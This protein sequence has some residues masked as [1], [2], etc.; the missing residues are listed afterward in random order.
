LYI[1]LTN[2]TFLGETECFYTGYPDTRLGGSALAPVCEHEQ[3]AAYDHGGDTSNCPPDLTG[4]ETARQD[5]DALEEPYD[6]RKNEKNCDD[7]NTQFH[8][9]LLS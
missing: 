6:P 2:A 8:S 7:I 5:V 3:S 1:A 4:H 9:L